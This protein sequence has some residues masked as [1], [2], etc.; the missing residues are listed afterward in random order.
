MGWGLAAAWLAVAGL[1]ILTFGTGVQAWANLAE[2]K[3]LRR[4]VTKEA[5]HA[6]K[7]SV[8]LSF[9]VPGLTASS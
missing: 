1:V 5:W 4:K 6:C 7:A 9:L 8:A 2:F 3:S